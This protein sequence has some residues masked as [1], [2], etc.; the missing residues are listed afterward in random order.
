MKALPLNSSHETGRIVGLDRLGDRLN[1][2]SIVRIIHDG[3]IFA[4]LLVILGAFVIGYAL[5]HEYRGGH[6]GIGTWHGTAQRNIAAAMV[7]ATEGLDDPGC[8][9]FTSGRN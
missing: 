2:G 1:L 8:G 4:A 7:V 5:G 6:V 3:A 9:P